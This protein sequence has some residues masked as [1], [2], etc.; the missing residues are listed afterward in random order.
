VFFALSTGVGAPDQTYGVSCTPP[1]GSAWDP[2]GVKKF[3][4]NRPRKP[5]RFVNPQRDRLDLNVTC[6]DYT[7]NNKDTVASV[8]DAFDQDI[9]TF[10]KT[11]ADLARKHAR[12]GQLNEGP[13]SYQNTTYKLVG[14]Y[15]E[16]Q[17]SQMLVTAQKV[18]HDQN[19]VPSNVSMEC[20]NYDKSG[21]LTIT[22]CD[23]VTGAG[24]CMRM[25][26]GTVGCY[27]KYSLITVPNKLTGPAWNRTVRVCNVTRPF[28]KDAKDSQV[29][30][31]MFFKF[32]I[33]ASNAKQ[34]RSPLPPMLMPVV[35]ANICA[36]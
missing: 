8:V 4:G 22:T 36:V 7:L 20:S 30:G 19:K 24:P 26:N 35:Y 3:Y 16:R 25:G 32:V 34:L 28:F 29:R 1:P 21:K 17:L 6:F 10:V 12:Q 18:L 15:N 31:K 2:F 14:T 11:Q 27:L 13:W 23:A 33:D 9:Q 5:V